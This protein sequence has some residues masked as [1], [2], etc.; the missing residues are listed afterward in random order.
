MQCSGAQSC[1]GAS[2]HCPDL[3]QCTIECGG[4]AGP[5]AC[6][7]AKIEC[8]AKGVCYLGCTGLQSCAGSTMSCGG[9]SCTSNCMGGAEAPAV[10]CGATCGCNHC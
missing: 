5:Q 6:D 10:T 7:N 3:Y 4:T 1:Q 9:N 8:S 2:I